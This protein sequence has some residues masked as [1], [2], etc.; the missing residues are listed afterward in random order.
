MGK[1]KLFCDYRVIVQWS[2]AGFSHLAC[3]LQESK[4][5]KGIPPGPPAPPR[6]ASRRP[7]AAKRHVRN[8]PAAASRVSLVGARPPAVSTRPARRTHAGGTLAAAAGVAVA[9]HLSQERRSSPLEQLRALGWQPGAVQV[10]AVASG[11]R[12][13]GAT[14]WHIRPGRWAGPQR[15]GSV[16]S[17]T[18]SGGGCRMTR[19]SINLN[20][21]HSFYQFSSLFFF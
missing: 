10:P 5:A 17:G 3:C 4:E 19:R 9:G 12:G 1:N 14:S 7:P 8:G 15:H 11:R 6:L 2:A 20:P 16:C 18:R 13:R 21:S